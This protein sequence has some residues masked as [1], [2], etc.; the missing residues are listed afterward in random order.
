MTADKEQLHAAFKV[1]HDRAAD[2]GEAEVAAR[3]WLTAVSE[4][5]DRAREATHQVGAWTEELRAS[6]SALE[7]LVAE[8]ETARIVFD[9]AESGCRAAREE[10]AQCEELQQAARPVPAPS[11]E[12]PLSERWPGDG[13]P[14]FERRPVEPVELDQ[15][16]AVIRIL[17]GDASAREAVVVA[18]AGDDVDARPAWQV[19]VARLTDAIM[20]RAIE[21]GYLDLPHDDPFWGLFDDDE[22]RAIVGAL[23]SL[24]FRYDGMQGFADERVPSA[25]DLSLAVGYAGL[26]RM[27]IR[28]WPG[29]GEL[30][31]LY[32][33]ASTQADMW[34]AHQTD[35]LALGRVIDAL[36]SRAADLGEV[37]DAWGRVRPALLS[38]D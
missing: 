26:D 4:L 30:A 6:S 14:A 3:S 24:G 23:A 33:R 1:A 37:W 27:R 13:D 25:R 38:E 15:L 17:R 19:R 5:N 28:T 12:D 35:D 36:G 34:L 11:D 31:A 32:G 29:P 16:P 8:A 22:Q 20:A 21:D 10:L 2:A 7:R 9:R 18:L